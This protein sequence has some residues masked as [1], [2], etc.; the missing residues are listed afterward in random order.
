MV[1]SGVKAAIVGPPNVGK[2]SILNY[3]AGRKAAIVSAI[4]GT[5]RDAIEVV[6]DVAGFKVP[7]R[8]LLRR[9]HA[10]VFLYRSE[11]THHAFYCAACI[12]LCHITLHHMLEGPRSTAALRVS[13]TNRV[14]A[15]SVVFAHVWQ[16][17]IV[18]HAYRHAESCSLAASSLH[19][20]V[21]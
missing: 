21:M 17:H 11:Y 10:Y 15:S 20:P 14:A 13:Q 6:L 4:P 8:M 3:L 19:H 2:S 18:S 9:H 1:R 5:T 16:R 7:I 12:A